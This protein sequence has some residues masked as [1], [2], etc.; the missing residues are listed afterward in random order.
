M[1]TMHT[2]RRRDVQ[3]R[4]WEAM[5]ALGAGALLAT[6]LR[7][8]GAVLPPVLPLVLFCCLVVGAEVMSVLLPSSFTVSPGFMFTMAATTAFTAD[9][10]P[11]HTVVIGASLVGLSEGL[12]LD[13]LRERRWSVVV[14]N[15]S[16]FALSAAAGAAVYSRLAPNPQHAAVFLA[17]VVAISAYMVVNLGLLVPALCLRYAA[18][19]RAVWAELRPTLPNSLA[20]GLLG[21]LVGQL[22]NSLGPLTL[23]LLLVPAVIARTTFA[24]YLELQKAHEGAVQVFVKAIEAKDRYTAGHCE[25]VAK[26]AAYIGEELGFSPGRMEHLRYAALMHDVGKLAVPSRLLN[27]PGRLTAEEYELIRKHNDVCIDILTRVDFL[28]TTV[29]AASDKHAHY[30]AEPDTADTAEG[31]TLEAY[32][33]AVADAFDAMTSTRSYR[34]AL[35]QDVAFQELRDKAGTQFH[36]ASAEA[37][38]RAIERRAEVYGDGHEEQVEE[39]DVPPPAAGVGSAGLGDL[40][41]EGASA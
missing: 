21:V 13:V 30:Q 25:R 6:L 24:S 33:I 27:K 1:E 12:M 7:T 10:L 16:Q 15:C 32:A 9:H 20:F 41:P 26:Y 22:Y 11:V 19:P 31:E 18:R 5:V 8:P 3:R 38:I 34:R 39:F 4:V 28:R 35:T 23:P 2:E 37:L 36:P 17:A 29:P 40:A 14:F